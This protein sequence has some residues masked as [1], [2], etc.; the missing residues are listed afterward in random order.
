MRQAMPNQG[1]GRSGSQGMFLRVW[2]LEPQESLPRQ[3]ESIIGIRSGP[4]QL[5][6]IGIG[7]DGDRSHRKSS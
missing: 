1:P 6:A 3:D 5:E 2:V 4:L 7:I